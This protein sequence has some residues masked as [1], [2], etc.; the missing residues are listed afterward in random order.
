MLGPEKIYE[1]L[2]IVFLYPVLSVYQIFLEQMYIY[3]KICNI[4]FMS[5][6]NNAILK[7]SVLGMNLF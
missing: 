4:T 2:N 3:Q 5:G 6:F 1:K 7:Y